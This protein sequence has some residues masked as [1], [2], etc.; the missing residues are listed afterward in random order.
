MKLS[1]RIV[2]TAHLFVGDGR[3]A[4]RRRRRQRLPACSSAALQGSFAQ[5]P[6]VDQQ[7]Q[8]RRRDQCCVEAGC[9]EHRSCQGFEPAA[10]RH[11]CDGYR[12]ARRRSRVFL[13]A[14]TAHW[15]D[16]EQLVVGDSFWPGCQ[17]PRRNSL[18]HADLPNAG[19]HLGRLP[20]QPRHARRRE[21]WCCVNSPRRSSASHDCREAK[22]ED[23]TASSEPR[24]RSA[25]YAEK[26]VTAY[27]SRDAAIY[28]AARVAAYMNIRVFMCSRVSYV[29]YAAKHKHAYTRP[30]KKAAISRGYT[31]R[32]VS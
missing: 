16:R 18:A 3:C 17:H 8:S 19:P 20:T 29:I 9:H 15:R 7:H 32:R 31:C 6:P 26:R 5:E 14:Q 27:R 13:R 28:A 11:G 25:R 24:Q 12:G 4:C 30:S 21:H 2:G 1:R 22:A 10:W 23:R